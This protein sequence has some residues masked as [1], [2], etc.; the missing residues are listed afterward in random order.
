MKV[1]DLL[2][3]ARGRRRVHTLR[4]RVEH[5]FGGFLAWLVKR[6]VINPYEMFSRETWDFVTFQILHAQYQEEVQRERATAQAQAQVRAQLAEPS[7]EFRTM[8]V[9]AAAAW[10]DEVKQSVRTVLAEP[11]PAPEELV[12]T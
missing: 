1:T 6:G 9:A 7:P 4:E 5:H 10:P 2:D 11:E 12:S 3:Y 8:L